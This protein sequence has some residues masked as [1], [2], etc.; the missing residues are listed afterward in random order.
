MSS[1]LWIW[2]IDGMTGESSA[3]ALDSLIARFRICRLGKRA[4][5]FLVFSFLL[6]FTLRWYTSLLVFAHRCY[7]LSHPWTFNVFV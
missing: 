5:T 3:S 6:S 4:M 7:C 2:D 1:Q